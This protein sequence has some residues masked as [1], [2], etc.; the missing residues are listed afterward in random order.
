MNKKMIIPL[1][2]VFLFSS[3]HKAENETLFPES[4]PD[5]E[6]IV[7]TTTAESSISVS[8]PSETV[9]IAV[10]ENASLEEQIADTLYF[11]ASNENNPI[12]IGNYS[13]IRILDVNDDLIPEIEVF[14]A[15]GSA[16]D[17]VDFYNLEGKYIGSFGI[18]SM[19]IKYNLVEKNNQKLFMVSGESINYNPQ[20]GEA[21]PTEYNYINV[22]DFD[23]EENYVYFSYITYE[24]DT[25]E[26]ILSSSVRTDNIRIDDTAT[27]ENINMYR[28]EFMSGYDTVNPIEPITLSITDADLS[29]KDA[30][31]EKIAEQVR[32]YEMHR[33]E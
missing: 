9:T 22:F 26:N 5:T 27:I 30:I 8:E 32:E 7:R 16:A 17:F 2:T 13:L 3:C 4:I 33:M 19:K 23:N 1:L 18:P 25:L 14:D 24:D 6:S 15:S 12:H 29:S 31:I 11:M 28:D 20:N 10:N 21:G